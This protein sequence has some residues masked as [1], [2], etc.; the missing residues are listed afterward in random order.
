MQHQHLISCEQSSLNKAVGLGVGAAT[1][2]SYDETNLKATAAE[3][4]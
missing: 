4:K 1:A 2:K 3:T